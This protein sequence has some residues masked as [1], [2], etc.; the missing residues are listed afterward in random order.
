M[1][2]FMLVLVG[3]LLLSGCATSPQANS[4][5]SS[6]DISFA[7]QMIPH[8]EQAIEMSDLALLNTSNADVLKLAG[9]IKNAQSPEIE[10]MQS[11]TGVRASTHSGH[12]MDGMLSKYELSDLANAKGK[13][14]DQLFFQGMIKHHEGAIK[15]AQ[16]VLGS[17]NKEV[18]AL[19][20]SIIK[21]QESEIAAMQELLVNS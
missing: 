10:K 17:T 15:M 20:S 4:E 18:A 19:A 21:A 12:M 8:H 5:Y 13:E 6:T 7:E 16:D 3:A 9:Q 11:W 2:K 14:F 1:K